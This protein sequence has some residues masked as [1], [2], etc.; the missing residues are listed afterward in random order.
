MKSDILRT[1]K[2][3]NFLI[4]HIIN[5][6]TPSNNFVSSVT[7]VPDIT[8]YLTLPTFPSSLYLLKL[9]H[10]LHVLSHT[11][12]KHSCFFGIYF[13]L[14]LPTPCFPKGTPDSLKNLTS[15]DSVTPTAFLPDTTIS[16]DS[17][18]TTLCLKPCRFYSRYSLL[19]A[20]HF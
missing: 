13:K 15:Q 18:S 4:K 9:P 6:N 11:F 7:F 17:T 1:I 10:T 2:C 8:N 3:L 19:S 12:P 20:F 16:M 5:T 14:G